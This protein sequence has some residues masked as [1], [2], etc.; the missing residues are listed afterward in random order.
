MLVFVPE[1]K[2]PSFIILDEP[3]STCSPGVRTH[4]IQEFLP[5]LMG[6]VPHVFW[7]TPLDT[8]IFGDVPTWT[9]VKENGVSRIEGA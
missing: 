5:K 7:I 1:H 9:I 3:D 8:E 2:R 6:I 4:L